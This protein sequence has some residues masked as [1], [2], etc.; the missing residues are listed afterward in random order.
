MKT[1]VPIS[2]RDHAWYVRVTFVTL[3]ALLPLALLAQ[4]SGQ[5]APATRTQPAAQSGANWADEI[6]NK[7]GYATP[8]AELASA[9]LAPRHLNVSLNTLSPDK[10]WFLNEIG[11]G[12]TSIAVYSRPFD[13]LGGVFIDFKANRARTLTL[14]SSVG[15]QL[16]SA[17]DGSKKPVAVPPNTRVSGA[18]F[19]PDGAAVAYLGHTDDATHIWMTDIAANKPRQITKTPLWESSVDWGPRG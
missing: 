6:I 18:R 12:P 16:V 8:P 4:G 5:S 14:R 19:T 11:D 17:A 15:I 2:R 10:K 13:E 3:V 9:V 1:G 7:E